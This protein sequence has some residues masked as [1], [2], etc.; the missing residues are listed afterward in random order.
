V[1]GARLGGERRGVVGVGERRGRL[2][3]AEQRGERRGQLGAV[4]GEARVAGAAR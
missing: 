3:R 2:A 4:A 1:R